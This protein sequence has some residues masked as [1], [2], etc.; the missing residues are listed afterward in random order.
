MKTIT[1]LQTLIEFFRTST[2][3]TS[4]QQR[5]THLQHTLCGSQDN[6]LVDG[7]AAH[8][9]ESTITFLRCYLT[10]TATTTAAFANGTLF[11]SEALALL[12]RHSQVPYLQL[13]RGPARGAA[14]SYQLPCLDELHLVDTASISVKAMDLFKGI[15]IPA[16]HSAIFAT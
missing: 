8:T 4:T 15:Q 14:Q 6:L 9:C 12:S 10:T 13:P 11:Q 3:T 1:T 7:M 16:H 5:T 2:T